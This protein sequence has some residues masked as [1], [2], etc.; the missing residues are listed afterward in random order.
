MAG[1][2]ARSLELAKAS[3]SVVKADKE[4]MLLPVLSLVA[5]LLVA[6]SFLGPVF[7]SGWLDDGAAEADT[8]FYAWVLAFYIATYFVTIFFNTA[9]VGA[10]M[11]RLD[12]G[13]PTLKAALA[14]AWQRVG[15]IFGYACIAG[16]VGLL[17]RALEERV[18]WLGRIVVAVIGIAWTLTTFLVVPVL[19]ARDLGPVEAVKE[20]A[21]MLRETWGE[22][23]VGNIGMGLIFL[24]AFVALFLVSGALVY[25]GITLRLPVLVAVVAGL[26]VI[27]F[28]L[29]AT[30][31]AT[32]QGVYSAA[33]YRYAAGDANR[34]VGFGPELM[35]QA[36]RSK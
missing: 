15:R 1:K 32:L 11:I 24:L 35:A 21:R 18:G 33:L 36:F 10:A 22:N 13:D 6:A 9:L 23:L 20:S 5:T 4:L 34:A 19:V 17:L 14:I 27:G 25:L 29:L 31:Q 2:F 30:L 12:G 28:L 7:A 8:A 26:A 16:T 3:W